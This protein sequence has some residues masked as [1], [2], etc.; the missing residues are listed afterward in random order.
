MA[1]EESAIKAMETRLS[2]LPPTAD[3]YALSLEYQAMR[4]RLEGTMS[5]WEENSTRLEHLVAMRG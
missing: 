1:D 4:E 3:V 5:A 2:N